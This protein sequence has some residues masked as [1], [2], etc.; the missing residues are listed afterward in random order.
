MPWA[1][2]A[3]KFYSVVSKLTLCMESM[4]MMSSLAEPGTT[5]LMV[6]TLCQQLTVMALTPLS[7]RDRYL[8]IH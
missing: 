8:I 5:R 3:L 6:M 2:I 1:R 7:T 4:G